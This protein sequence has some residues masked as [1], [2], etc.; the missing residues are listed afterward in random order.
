MHH[1]PAALALMLV[2]LT[3]AVDGQRAPSPAM[4][5]KS[6]VIDVS[7]MARADE[8]IRQAIGEK[9]LPGA[10]LLVGRGDDIVYERAYGNRAVVP[11]I[12]PMTPDTIFDMASV[13][14]VV[15][16]TTSVMILIEDGRIRLTD[17]VAT[18]IP[19]FGKYGKNAITIRH[20]LTHV[21]GLRPDI[22][23]NEEFRGAESA[24]ER[25]C[26]E[27]PVAAPGERFIYSDINFFLLGD[28]VR[29][30]SGQPLDLF[31]RE[32]VF[33]PLGMTET[34]FNPPESWR[35]RIA[36]TESCTPLGWPCQ[37][38]NQVMLRGVVHDPTARRMDGVAGHAGLFSTSH[39]LSK[40]CRMLLGGG[41]LNG[42]RILSPLTVAK[43]TT[44]ATEDGMASRRGLGWDLDSAYSS[45]RGELFPIGSFGHTGFTGTSL[46]IDPVTRAYVV[47]LSNRVHPDGKGD[48]TPLRARVATVVASA[49]RDPAPANVLREQIMTGGDF[50][51]SGAAARATGE[52]RT[53]NGVDVL[54]AEGFK[55]SPG[56]DGW[57]PHQPHWAYPHRRDDHRCAG[58]RT[59]REAGRAVQPGAWHP[60][61]P[62]RE[63]RYLARREDRAPDLFPLRC[64]AAPDR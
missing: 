31:A 27:V 55:A 42:V 34:T 26:E 60:R 23:L 52:G 53:L 2:G 8:L 28:I 47:F 3:L 33:Q 58:R 49:L 13:T 54:L 11:A 48:V 59:R 18:F 36:P 63:G 7:R 61:R 32:R 51:A 25:A 41:A 9:L 14:K 37:G 30:V 35:G 15:A 29:R 1:R 24:I 12:E 17:R 39:D 62:G 57:A 64:D 20:L 56:Q 21:S 45:N 19:G 5:A 43:M 16:T 50:G 40:F 4:T 38:P 10:V 22:D 6:A 44:R 46:W